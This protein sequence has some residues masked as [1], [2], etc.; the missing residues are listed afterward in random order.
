MMWEKKINN[1]G[2]DDDNDARVDILLLLVVVVFISTCCHAGSKRV[3]VVVVVVV[4]VGD[5][6][7]GRLRTHDGGVLLLAS[8]RG[9]LGER[10]WGAPTPTDPSTTT[11]PSHWG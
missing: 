11:M 1:D 8:S 2:G 4:V 5:G 7:V 3:V 10:E 6:E 9:A